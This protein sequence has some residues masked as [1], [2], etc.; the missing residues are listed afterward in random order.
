MVVIQASH[1]RTNG[2]GKINA[3]QLD[4][5]LLIMLRHV[6]T[7]HMRIGYWR[8]DICEKDNKLNDFNRKD[9]FLQHV[10][11]M[12]PKKNVKG[13]K[14]SDSPPRSP[15]KANS[16]KEGDAMAHRCYRKTRSLPKESGCHFCEQRFE[17]TNTWDERMEHV[18]AHMDT[19]KKDNGE[20]INMK[21]WK[22]DDDLHDYL[23][24]EGIVRVDEKTKGPKWVLV[25]GSK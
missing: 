24:A 22:H 3:A 6:F 11:R 23:V 1:R 5:Y 20:A 9:L 15:K 10:K 17:G 25:D 18:G 12:H 4:L 8:C 7:Q 2:S 19:S 21:D 13:E 16:D 14:G